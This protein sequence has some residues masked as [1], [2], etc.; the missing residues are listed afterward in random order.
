[1]GGAEMI[2]LCQCASD[3]HSIVHLSDGASVNGLHR[4]RASRGGWHRGSGNRGGLLFLVKRQT[5]LDHAVNALG[6]G[7]G[8]LQLET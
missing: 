5:E 3:S 7:G 6:V 4:G 1:M 8:V 2:I